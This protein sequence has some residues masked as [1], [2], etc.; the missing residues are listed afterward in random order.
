[1]QIVDLTAEHECAFL[2]CLE[3]WSADM[4]E[5][6]HQRRL[7]Y[8][9]M[10][11]KGLRV[12]LAFADNGGLGGFI[13]YLPMEHSILEGGDG[14]F[15]YC[16]WV[17]GHKQGRGNLQ[18]K[19]L[20]TAL[21]KAAEQD[22]IALKGAGVAAWGLMLPFWMK[23]SWFV[24]HGY[25]KVDRDGIAVLVYKAFQDNAKPPRWRKPQRK[26]EKGTDKVKISLFN[27]GW[28]AAQNISYER[29][30]RICGD[31][32]DRILLEEYNTRDREVLSDWGIS[33]AIY[34][35]GKLLNTGPPPS[36]EK[37]KR[38]VLRQIKRRRI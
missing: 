20:G 34:V 4:A 14:Y 37:L 28:C 27:H 32:S 1:M 24:K 16:I 5:A 8:D 30:K 23:A 36:Y 12:K 31:L 33:D 35:D 3:E 18:K 9:E 25:R 15:I 10:K 2:Q 19:G 7:W 29:I 17:H 38:I 21:L 22:I 11:H 6:G 13:Q 26:P